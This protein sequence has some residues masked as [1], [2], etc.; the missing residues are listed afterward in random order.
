MK[1]K[2][3]I[4]RTDPYATDGPIGEYN[5]GVAE[6]IELATGQTAA[7]EAEVKAVDAAIIADEVVL[8][9]ATLGIVGILL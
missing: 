3:S 9:T 5:A 6:E 8:S 2:V 7:A 1:A 4:V